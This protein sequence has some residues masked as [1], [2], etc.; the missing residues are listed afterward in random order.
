LFEAFPGME[1]LNVQYVIES[2]QGAA[3]L[4]AASHVIKF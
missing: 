4:T 3:E 1:K 2:K